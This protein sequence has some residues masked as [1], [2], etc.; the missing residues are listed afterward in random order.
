MDPLTLRFPEPQIPSPS[1][2][3]YD[4]KTRRLSCTVR[5]TREDQDDE[6]CPCDRQVRWRKYGGTVLTETHTDKEAQGVVPYSWRIPTVRAADAPLSIA[7]LGTL[8]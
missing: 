2:Y 5:T 4:P 1:L 3:F 8:Y 7:S 6:L